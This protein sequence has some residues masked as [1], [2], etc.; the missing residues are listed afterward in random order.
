[1]LTLRLLV[2]AAEHKSLS[3][4]AQIANLALAAVSRRIINFEAELGIPVFTRTRSGVELTPAG[5]V[6]LWRAERILGEANLLKLDM[7]DFQS[8]MRGRVSIRASTSAVAQFLPEDLAAFEALH[9]G[10][11]LEIREA[12]SS[13]I[14]AE[15]RLGQLDVGIILEGSEAFGLKTWPYRKDRLAV[16]A[17]AAFRPDIQS[18]RF[19]DILEGDMIQMGFDTAMTKLL[20]ARANEVGRTLRLRVEVD[21][22]D[23]VCRMVAAGFGIGILPE[24]AAAS[25]VHQLDLR[26]IKLDEPWAERGMLI[27][28]KDDKPPSNPAREVIDFL[29]DR[30]AKVNTSPPQSEG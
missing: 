28:V 10:I 30:A 8:G 22:F 1:L 14:I 9:A 20:S 23:A 18:I 17:P 6:C 2:L 12:Y 26:L 4:T 25:L 5:E 11:R 29:V 24:I 21:S 19:E 16:V 7:A 3:K 13:D 27:A 15:L